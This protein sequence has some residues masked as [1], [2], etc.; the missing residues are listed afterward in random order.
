MTEWRGSSGVI[1]RAGQVKNIGQTIGTHDEHLYHRIYI[2][3][4]CLILMNSARTMFYSNDV[5]APADVAP[6]RVRRVIGHGPCARRQP[7]RLPGD[8]ATPN[9]PTKNLPTKI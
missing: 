8:L 4:P 1:G 5:F 6:V 7:L 3:N 2:I 9:L